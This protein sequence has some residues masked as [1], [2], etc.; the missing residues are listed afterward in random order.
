[1]ITRSRFLEGSLSLLAMVLFCT[2][3]QAVELVKVACVGDSITY[4]AAIQD[5]ENRNYPVQL[6]QLLGDGY[7][8]RNF[9]VNGATL[10][11]NGDLP[12]WTRPQFKMATEFQP[13]IVII[14]LGTNDSKPQ[15]WKYADRYGDD[16]QAMITHFQTLESRPQIFVCRPVPVATDRWGI[17]EAVVHDEVIPALNRAVRKTKGVK[18]IDLYKVLAPHPQ[19]IPDGVHPNGEGAGLMADAIYK[20][21]R[22]LRLN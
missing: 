5:R 17:T 14:K 10:L 12:Y 11:K 18:V 20:R 2:S 15:N 1:M 4:G 22:R 3:L 7:D 21:L 19:L 9:G 8:V 6:G 13:D 16:L